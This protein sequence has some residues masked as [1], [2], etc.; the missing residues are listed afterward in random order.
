MKK[1]LNSLL[2]QP[3]WAGPPLPRI[4]GQKWPWASEMQPAADPPEYRILPEMPEIIELHQEGMPAI[5]IAARLNVAP[6]LVRYR[7]RRRGFEPIVAP[8]FLKAAERTT[9]IL[10]LHQEG[11]TPKQI[12]EKLGIDWSLVHRRLQDAELMPRPSP[13]EM[14]ATVKGMDEIVRLAKEDKPRHEIARRTGSTWPLVAEALEESSVKRIIPACEEI[15]SW[16]STLLPTIEEIRKAAPNTDPILR[17]VDQLKKELAAIADATWTAEQRLPWRGK[18]A[19]KERWCLGDIK[20]AVSKSLDTMD[21]LRGCIKDLDIE[22]L[23][24]R[25]ERARTCIENTASIMSGAI[26]QGRHDKLS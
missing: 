23:P 5:E 6:E 20:R 11:F 9:D 19:D 24:R 1:G 4:L 12:A 21:A 7:L 15:A 26:C 10:R 17:K 22:K 8:K 16:A 13:E 14:E 3:P 25:L 18:E 2:P